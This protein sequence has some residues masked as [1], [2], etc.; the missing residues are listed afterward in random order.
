MGMLKRFLGGH[1]I[2]PFLLMVEKNSIKLQL[3]GKSR[4]ISQ[5]FSTISYVTTESHEILKFCDH[6][7]I[8]GN[9]NLQSKGKLANRSIIKLA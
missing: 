5:F 8:I 2:P 6:E 1:V 4:L 7:P 3:T 9:K